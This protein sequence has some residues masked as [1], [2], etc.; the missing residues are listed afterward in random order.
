M[1]ISK[2]EAR[3]L[4]RQAIEMDAQVL[5]GVLKL[6]PE[7]ITINETDLSDWLAR[8]ANSEVI[9]LAAAIDKAKTW[10]NLVKTCQQCGRDYEGESCTYCADVRARL[11]GN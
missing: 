6:G 5:R 10:D 7:E 2:S 11:R 1:S 8:Y 3:R 9:L 4:T